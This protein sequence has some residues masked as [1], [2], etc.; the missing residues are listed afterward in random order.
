MYIFAL[1]SEQITIFCSETSEP[2]YMFPGEVSDG[3]VCWPCGTRR[4]TETEARCNKQSAIYNHHHGKS[5]G[6]CTI[7][8]C[9]DIACELLIVKT[10]RRRKATGKHKRH[11]TLWWF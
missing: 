8:I 3:S 10:R 6:H 7:P 9:T 1:L 2:I 4:I 11:L 5:Y